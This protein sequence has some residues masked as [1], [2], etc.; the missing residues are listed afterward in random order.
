MG[1]SLFYHG[2]WI[3]TWRI[4]QSY[5]VWFTKL[6]LFYKTK[7]ITF[8]NNTFWWSFPVLQ[9]A[10]EMPF[11]RACYAKWCSASRLQSWLR[12]DPVNIRIVCRCVVWRKLLWPSW[13][14]TLW[15]CTMWP[16][17]VETWSRPSCIP[18][19]S[20]QI[21]PS[22]QPAC[23][24]KFVQLVFLRVEVRQ[25]HLGLR[26]DCDSPWGK[27]GGSSQ[28]VQPQTSWTTV[29]PSSSCI[30]FRCEDDSKLL[31]TSWQHICKYQLSVISW[32]HTLNTWGQTCRTGPHG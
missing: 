22:Y 31:A 16:T 21:L 12:P 23:F 5:K 6:A 1:R 30:R 17:W 26:F 15:H 27:P 2:M 24:R 7:L 14:G 28:R 3:K 11:W 10:W 25:L 8:E 9:N 13:R 19:L 29:A 4:A 18:A 32:G 20:Q